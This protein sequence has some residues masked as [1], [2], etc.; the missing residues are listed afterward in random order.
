M[1]INIV[2]EGHS[3]PPSL[4]HA[5]DIGTVH[6]WNQR[7]SNK[8]NIFTKIIDPKKNDCFFM[9]EPVVVRP[10]DFD[11]NNIKKFYKVFTWFD[12]FD[13]PNIVK[14]N[15]PS[16]L[17]NP[18]LK[19]LKSNPSWDERNNEIVI[20]ANPKKS[21]HSASIYSIREKL[22][23]ELYQKGF[24]ISWYGQQ[25]IRKPYYVGS[26]DNKLQILKKA[27]FS[28]CSENTYDPLYSKNYLTE[29][30]PHVLI[31]GCVPMYIGCHNIDE[32][33]MNDK[34][35]I[36]LRKYIK[37]PPNTK[38]DIDALAERI[39]NFNQLDYNTYRE[40]I[41]KEIQ[42]P[43]GLFHRVSYHTAYETMLRTL[44]Q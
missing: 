17:N 28:I 34:S 10:Q 6:V 38:F 32:F 26:V 1:N 40:E 22:A 31:S 13:L 36:D 44:N 24:K 37:V 39:L 15:F 18:T 11:Q 41:Y 12:S 23:D 14:I 2:Y 43:N 4:H 21:S 29:K 16:I 9:Q 3:G 25:K 30:L 42:K 35:M 19:D 27:R 7:D 20:I 5:S 8:F 33:N